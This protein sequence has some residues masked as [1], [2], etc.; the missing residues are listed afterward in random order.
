MSYWR[1]IE[2]LKGGKAGDFFH[3]KKL[4]KKKIYRLKTILSFFMTRIDKNMT[5]LNL[6]GRKGFT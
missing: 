1:E 3:L 5:I 2:K 4:K 6:C